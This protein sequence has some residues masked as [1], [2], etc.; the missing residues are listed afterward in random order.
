M[1]MLFDVS[2]TGLE[3]VTAMPGSWRDQ[4]F[5]VLLEQ[6]ELDDLDD[7]AGSDLQEIVLMALQDREPEDA[8][9]AVL[10]SKLQQRAKPGVRQNIVRDLLK[11]QR[12]WE[13]AADIKLHAGIF[14][15]AMLLRQAF[16][17]IFPRPDI[18][19]LTL[20]LRGLTTDAIKLLSCPPEAAFVAR[21]IADGMDESSV[22][23]RLFDAKL[24]SHSFPEADSIIWRA[25]FSNPLPGDVSAVQLS[26][27]SSA[28]WLSAMKQ[29][30]SYRSQA[31][32]DTMDPTE[33]T[34]DREHA[35]EQV[36]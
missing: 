19:H 23:E 1:A 16:P 26:V 15:S 3:S 14:A 27:Y 17:K 7:I 22:L 18:L 32:N 31:Y 12:P 10:A 29:V 25:E 30:S 21:V 8:A 2:V 6:L 34:I 36:K 5:R 20:Q 4:D 9:D 35:A 33:I 28:H 11:D 24:A 13:E